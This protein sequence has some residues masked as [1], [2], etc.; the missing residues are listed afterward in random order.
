MTSRVQGSLVD[1][2][3]LCRSGTE[4]PQH[5][6]VLQALLRLDNEHTAHP[7]WQGNS[8]LPEDFPHVHP[9]QNKTGPPRKTAQSMTNEKTTRA[10]AFL[11]VVSELE[12]RNMACALTVD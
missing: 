2:W 7:L 10:M 1:Q 8:K 9:E 4:G 5:H 6:G 3:S 12:T 11:K